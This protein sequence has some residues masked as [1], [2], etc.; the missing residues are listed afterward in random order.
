M[1]KNCLTEEEMYELYC[2]EAGDD[3][4]VEIKEHIA[5]CESCSK[6]YAIIV[7]DFISL[8][9]SAPDDGGDRALENTL[10][11]LGMAAPTPKVAVEDEILTIQEAA[12]WLKVKENNILN[13]LAII[14]HFII[15]GEIRIRKEALQATIRDLEKASQ[16]PDKHVTNNLFLQRDVI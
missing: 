6:Q 16:T 10:T 12:N 13:M 14:P 4:C 1:R 3:Q 5:K 11:S 2:L 9:F 15:D 8:E 7:E